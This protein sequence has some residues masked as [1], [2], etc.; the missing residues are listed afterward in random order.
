MVTRMNDECYGDN[1]K[2][3]DYYDTCGYI[4]ISDPFKEQEK[5]Q[6]SE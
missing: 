6:R 1:C 5:K 3:C 2:V 4:R